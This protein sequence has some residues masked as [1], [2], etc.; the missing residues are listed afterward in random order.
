MQ[1]RTTNIFLIVEFVETLNFS[2]FFIKIYLEIFP[3]SWYQF[4]MDQCS[5]IFYTKL[6]KEK[7]W[8]IMLSSS[9]HKQR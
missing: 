1:K 9:D 8:N 4:M 5:F 7:S 2:Y 6:E 3:N